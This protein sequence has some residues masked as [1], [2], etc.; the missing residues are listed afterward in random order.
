MPDNTFGSDLG[1]LQQL[2]QNSNSPYARFFGSGLQDQANPVAQGGS[3]PQANNYSQMFPNHPRVAQALNNAGLV[4]GNIQQ[5]ETAGENI[6]SVARSVTGLPY[7]RMMQAYGM[8]N[9]AF[10]TAQLSSKLGLEAGQTY[11]ARQRGAMY[12]VEPQLRLQAEQQRMQAE[13]AIRMEGQKPTP[14]FGTVPKDYQGDEK[15]KPG[16]SG[17][18]GNYFTE[19]QK[20]P[21]GSEA[22]DKNGNIQIVRRFEPTMTPEE[23]QQNRPYQAYGSGTQKGPLGQF[24]AE[25]EIYMRGNGI[26]PDKATDQD[27]FKAMQ[28]VWNGRAQAAGQNPVS[29]ADIQK[30]NMAD[31]DAADKD[32]YQNQKATLKPITKISDAF[33]QGLIKTD[34]GAAP[35]QEQLKQLNADRQ[36]R[37]NDLDK[38]YSQYN[39]LPANGRPGF[40]K[41]HETNN[42]TQPGGAPPIVQ[43]PPTWNPKT[44][45]FE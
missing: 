19:I 7:A 37:L 2:L 22:R 45:R 4:M 9:P 31:Q 14:G 28:G 26:D 27:L 21:D 33:Q 41:F 42:S 18:W 20:N 38:S 29:Q 3:V 36:S 40:Q 24:G 15:F 44:A 43:H 12:G 23:A 32:F 35:P 10:E 16:Q 6:G 5:G 25:M 8:Y 17:V 30:K 34:P 39:K 11:E 1:Q 13:A